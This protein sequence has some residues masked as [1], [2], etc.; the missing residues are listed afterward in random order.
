MGE[1]CKIWAFSCDKISNFA[2]NRDHDFNPKK[3]NSQHN[4]GSV[5]TTRGRGRGGEGV[6]TEFS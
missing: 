4:L 1:K 2:K 3:L 6:A 5:I